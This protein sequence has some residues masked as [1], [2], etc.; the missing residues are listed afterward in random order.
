MLQ[1]HVDFDN[2]QKRRPKASLSWL[3]HYFEGDV[4]K[5]SSLSDA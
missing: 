2:G 4:P 1:V 5:T 3:H